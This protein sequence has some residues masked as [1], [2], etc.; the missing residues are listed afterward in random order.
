MPSARAFSAIF[1]TYVFRFVRLGARSGEIFFARRGGSQGYSVH[2][3]DELNVDLL[4]AAEDRHTG[5]LG[6]STDDAA[7][8]I[9]YS[10]S[11]FLFT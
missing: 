3:V 10:L 4:V 5:T 1:Q 9:A 6:A 2:V 7:D 11:S 8:A